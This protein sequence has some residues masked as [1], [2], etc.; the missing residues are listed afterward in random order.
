VQN[1]TFNGFWVES[2][3][4]LLE[5]VTRKNS[6]FTHGLDKLCMDGKTIELFCIQVGGN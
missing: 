3:E 1:E 2:L 4:P 6:F 5:I